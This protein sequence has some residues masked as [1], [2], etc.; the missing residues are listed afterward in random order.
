ML[1]AVG[2]KSVATYIG[3]RQAK[4]EKWMD[5]R[6]ILEVCT[7]EIGYEGVGRKIW[8]WWRQGVSEE[9]IRTTL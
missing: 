5:L 2:M 4:V 8:P 9:V 1:Q 3:H 7:Q 6:T